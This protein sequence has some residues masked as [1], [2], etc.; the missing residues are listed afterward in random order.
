MSD[1][2]VKFLGVSVYK[3]KTSGNT[4]TT[5]VLGLPVL[6]R[7]EKNNKLKKYFL[8]VKYAKRRLNVPDIPEGHPNEWYHLDRSKLNVMIKLSGGLG[9]YIIAINYINKLIQKYGNKNIRFYLSG[10]TKL[11]DVFDLNSVHTVYADF[12]VA[13]HTKAFDV[14][15]K[16]VR[17]PQ[18]LRADKKKVYRFSEEFLDY[19][20]ACEKFMIQQTRFFDCGRTC[21]GQVRMF[22]RILG[23]NR[24][25]TP[26]ILNLFDIRD[27]D[28]T[29]P[30]PEKELVSF[31]VMP[32]FITIHRGNDARQ[33]KTCVKLW[34]TSYYNILVRLMKR[35]YPDYQIVQLG[36]NKDRCLD[37][38]GVDLNLVG[39]TTLSD[40]ALLLKHA[41][42]HIDGE[43]GFVHL[44]HALK[45]GSCAVLFGPTDKAYYGYPEN[46]N[47]SA[48]V[49]R[50]CEWVR[51][52]WLESCA[53][54]LNKPLCMYALTP[55]TVFDKI[56]ESGVL[57]EKM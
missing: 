21:D 53:R 14:F 12:D 24:V 44:R 43:G 55:E 17:F 47:I 1:K 39:Q 48:D 7:V 25:Q 40:V 52:K 31:G 29:I 22:T 57:N 16:L 30:L 56:H 36:I 28:V 11:L 32:K 38:E 20:L 2:K 15:I 5:R 13:D 6:R 27:I 23:K 42:F 35:A 54:G 33:S 49:C 10:V 4:K 46:L 8:G 18:I 19:V 3:R 26:D 51:E 50:G 9:D 34:P 37:I 41:A 45:G